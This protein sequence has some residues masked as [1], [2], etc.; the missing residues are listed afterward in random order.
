MLSTI[1]VLRA[2][3][4]AA[5][6]P[7][8]AKIADVF[9]RG[10]MLILSVFFYVIG[11]IIQAASHSFEA[12][13]AGAVLY[14]VRP[15]VRSLSL[16][17]HSSHLVLDWLHHGHPAGRGCRRRHL[18]PQVASLRLL[19]LRHP[20]SCRSCQPS[21]TN[22][23]PLA[24]NLK[25]I[26]AWIS[27]NVTS[28]VLKVTTWRWGI[29]MWAIIY[30]ICALPLILTLTWS[31]RKAKKA[32]RLDNYQSPFQQLG[33]FGLMKALF[34][35][36]D[37]IGIILMI[38]VFGLIL[39]PFTL[40]GGVSS[41]WN[42]AKIIAPLVVGIVLVPVFVWWERT[43]KHALVPF[44]LLKDR[45][46]W[47][48]LAIGVM[49]DT[50]WYC[51]GDYLY[52]MLVISFNQSILSATRIS[53][54]YS[55]VSV[56]TGAAL[57]LVVVRVRRLKPFIIFGTCMWLVAFGLL[58]KYRGSETSRAGIIAGQVLLGFG[59]SWMVPRITV[60]S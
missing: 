46:V 17:T 45:G 59:E 35:Q 34:W 47:S 54:L 56:L 49:I 1:T 23:A 25:Q 9:G 5:A 32:G 58:I 53:S 19:H 24:D 52:P 42:Q 11:T 36:L 22:T 37:V 18:F 30:P 8:A 51:Q 26:N 7:T 50:I 40:A 57:G 21:L 2:V 10:E 33:F 44:H 31:A 55:F 20:I 12:F 39:T 14:Q 6:Q 16:C 38:C 27:G 15:L 28:S 43:T 4:A 3:I 29:G 41:N 13:S 60:D 48:A